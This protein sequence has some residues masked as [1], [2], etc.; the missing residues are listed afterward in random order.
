[1]SK[2]NRLRLV[3]NSG[4][5][6]SSQ[7]FSRLFT[8]VASIFLIRYLGVRGYG[9]YS[10]VVAY[11]GFFAVVSDLGM[12]QLIIR[13]SVWDRSKASTILG[14]FIFFQVL[15]GFV[16]FL[17]LVL[18]I[19]LLGYEREIMNAVYVY[20]VSVFISSLTVP[21][22][23]LISSFEK[24]KFNA[25]SN[26]VSAFL[27]AFFVLL[28]IYWQVNLVTIMIAYSIGAASSLLLSGF[29]CTGFVI[30]PVFKIN[31]GLW[32]KLMKMA[33]PFLLV[34]LFSVLYNKIDI[35]ILSKI[36]GDEA[37]GIYNGAYRL[38]D[39]WWVLPIAINNAFYPHLSSQF[40]K[41]IVMLKKN[42]RRLF[43]GELALGLAA[44]LFVFIMAPSLVEMLL[45][46]E[47]ASS[48]EVLKYLIWYVPLHLAGGVLAMSLTAINKAGKFALAA[49]LNFGFVFVGNIVL[50]SRYG[51]YGAVATTIFSGLF[52]LVTCWFFLRREDAI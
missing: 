13:E 3:K 39:V 49:G 11:V 29:F 41:N 10:V 5:L 50:I 4:F 43:W 35:L 32:M 24:M 19:N 2:N 33:F 31:L 6:L 36:K 17:V 15:V 44:S 20:G 26:T 8:F 27:T 1:M 45:G 38:V 48:A 7:V 14:N 23:S 25:I 37:V 21:F 47:Y 46:D 12:G 51:L 16:I 9:E 18:G 22:Q 52:L 40:K 30:K 34:S 28:M 42:I